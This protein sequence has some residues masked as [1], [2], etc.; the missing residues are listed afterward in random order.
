MGVNSLALLTCA[1]KVRHNPAAGGMQAAIG[2]CGICLG[3]RQG[4]G[5]TPVS[6]TIPKG[7][8]AIDKTESGKF[9]YG[10][11]DL[12]IGQKDSIISE[13][14]GRETGRG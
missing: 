4:C 7:K 13:G 12:E 8:C 6:A 1:Q 5:L 2:T 3:G 9:R 14:R 11:K 10:Y